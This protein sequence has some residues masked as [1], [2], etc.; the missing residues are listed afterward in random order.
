VAAPIPHRIMLCLALAA[1]AAAAGTAAGQTPPVPGTESERFRVVVEGSAQATRQLDLGGSNGIC[2]AQIG[3]EVN[4]TS[5]WRRGRGVVM[6]FTKLGPGPRAP[7][8]LTRVGSARPVLTVVVSV[9]RRSSGSAT[10]TAS[11][12]PEACPPL[13]EDLSVGPDCGIPETSRAI[14]SVLY[15][16]G[17][18]RV[19]QVGLGSVI[20]LRCPVSQVLGGTPE[21]RWGWPTAAPLRAEPVARGLIFGARRAFVVRAVSGRLR[22]SEPF[23]AGPLSGRVTDFGSS[24]VTVRF[25][26]LP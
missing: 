17:R 13:T 18:L 2:D 15:A 5:T 6:Q 22:D 23:V 3:I 9:T 12:P 11:G 16:G 7:V 14:V 4:E 10:R 8:I 21:L 20:D 19:R 24:A 26:R 25:I 1:C